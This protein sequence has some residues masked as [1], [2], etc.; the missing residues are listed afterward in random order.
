MAIFEKDRGSRRYFSQSTDPFPT[1]EGGVPSGSMLVYTDTGERLIF[2]G[3]SRV[4]LPFVGEEDIIS[5]LED[6]RD[7][8][9]DLLANSKVTRAAVATMANDQSDGNFSTDDE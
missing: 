2:D 6:I 3:D 1:P 7:G 4:W 8:I 5:V 9:G